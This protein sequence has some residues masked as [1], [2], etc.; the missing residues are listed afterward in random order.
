[1]EENIESVLGIQPVD[2]QTSG[3]ATAAPAMGEKSIWSFEGRIGRGSFWARWLLL[4]LSGFA[5]GLIEGAVGAA[6]ERSLAPLV[7]LLYL[8]WLIP[9]VWLSLAIQVKRWHDM[10]CSGLM[11]LWNFTILFVPV[12]FI[13]LGFVRGT[14]GPNKY[15]LAHASSGPSPVYAPASKTM[16]DQCG[17]SFPSSFYLEKSQ[18]SRYLC[19]KCRAAGPAETVEPPMIA[20]S[21][22]LEAPPQ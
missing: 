16:C 1:M 19:E 13:I 5:V 17:N 3:P 22:P 8:A 20:D 6:G 7:L 21:R 2:R 15:S 12:A 11:V 9:S 14:D 10:D 18:D 4:V